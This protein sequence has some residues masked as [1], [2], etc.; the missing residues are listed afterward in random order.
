MKNGTILNDKIDKIIKQKYSSNFMSN[1]KW[2]KLIELL[3]KNYKL[4]DVCNVKLI[5]DKEIRQLIIGGNENFEFD[6]YKDSM[7]GMIT[8]PITPGWVLYKEIEWISFPAEKSNIFEI[9]KLV[10][11]LGEFRN[12]LTTDYFR[13]FAYSI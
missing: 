2:V 1:S 12:D 6:Y 5:Y 4:F 8:K 10:N 3:V 9:N 11:Q 7:E 13:V